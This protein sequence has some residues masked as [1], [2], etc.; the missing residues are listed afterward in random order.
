LLNTLALRLGGGGH[1]IFFLLLSSF[2][3][4]DELTNFEAFA[5]AGLM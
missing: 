1:R 2:D 5:C 3:L 4:M